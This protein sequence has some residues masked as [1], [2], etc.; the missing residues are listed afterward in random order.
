MT[1]EASWLGSETSANDGRLATNIPLIRSTQTIPVSTVL[2]TRNIPC[3]PLADAAL[4][5]KAGQGPPSCLGRNQAQDGPWRA[6][7]VIWADEDDGQRRKTTLPQEVSPQERRSATWFDGQ[8]CS[9]EAFIVSL[10]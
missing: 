5:R 10:I 9:L 1:A 7:L 6:G 8:Y 4:R 2:L 3:P